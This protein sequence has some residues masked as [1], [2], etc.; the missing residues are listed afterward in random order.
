M[1]AFLRQKTYSRGLIFS[2]GLLIYLGTHE[3][4]LQVL[5]LRF[6]DG[7]KFRQ[8]NPKQKLMNLQYMASPMTLSH[9]TLSDLER[10]KLGC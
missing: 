4:C 9:M 1:F 3:L 5:F 10:S 7:R 6:K 2:S 8:I